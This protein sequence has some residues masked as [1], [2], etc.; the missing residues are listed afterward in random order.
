[1]RVKKDDDTWEEI[2]FSPV[3]LEDNS[4]LVRLNTPLVWA[5]C[6]VAD[7]GEILVERTDGYTM[8]IVEN[9]FFHPMSDFDSGEI[10]I[11]EDVSVVRGIR[12]VFLN[13]SSTTRNN[14]SVY[15]LE[16]GSDPQ[17]KWRLE[18]RFTE[19]DSIHST[20]IPSLYTNR[21]F[22]KWVHDIDFDFSRY[23]SDR[24]TGV[25]FNRPTSLFITLRPRGVVLDNGPLLKRNERIPTNLKAREVIN[26]VLKNYYNTSQKRDRVSSINPRLKFLGYKRVTIRLYFSVG[27]VVI[28]RGGVVSFEG[29]SISKPE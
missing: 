23:N 9:V 27:S 29:S 14:H 26:L 1:M 6:R 4:S 7:P 5:I 8:T 17:S 20:I 22:C 16:D 3:F 21:C 24:D 2:P 11:T 10:N 28:H 18:P 15:T 12:Y 25:V 19:R 13:E